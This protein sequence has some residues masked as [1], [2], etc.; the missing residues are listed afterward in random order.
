M[1]GRYVKSDESKKI[2]Y[3][4]AIN[5]YGQSMSQPLLY[6]EIEMWHGQP[7]PNMKKSEEFSITPDHSGFGYSIEVDLG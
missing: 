6:D 5:L 7:D 2:L 1:G 3:A 4:D